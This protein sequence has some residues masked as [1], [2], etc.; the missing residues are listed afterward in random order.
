MR[1]R[2][3]LNFCQSKSLLVFLIYFYGRKKKLF[4]IYK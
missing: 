2:G 4:L 1:I 3:S